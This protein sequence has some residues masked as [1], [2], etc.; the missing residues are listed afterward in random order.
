MKYI[1]VFLSLIILSNC[2]NDFVI[3]DKWKNIPLVYGI[4][5]TSEEFN[6]IRVEKAF[7]DESESAF[8]L[9]QRPDSLY[10]DNIIVKLQNEATNQ[11]INLERINVEDLGIEREAGIFASSPNILYRFKESDFPLNEDQI[12]NLSII[13]GVTEQI[14]TE[15][16]TTIVGQYEI[17]KSA[18]TNPLQFKY[19]SDFTITWRSDE[20]QAVF[21]DVFMKIHYEEQNPDNPSQWV[22]KELLWTLDQNIERSING[23]VFSPR[24][25]FSFNGKKFYEYLAQNI[26][27]SVQTLRAVTGIDII[28]DA[29]GQELLNYIDTGAANTGITSNQIIEPYTNMS[30]GQG[31]FSS[32]SRVEVL[33]Y[34]LNAVTRD[35]LREGIITRHLNFQ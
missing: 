21:Y 15:S 12:V 6:Y 1:L 18:P 13:D 10:Y 27:D 8:T 3:I 17:S 35:S 32:K 30:S 16:T 34:N 4:L 9:A 7:I 23:G 26:D 22:E 28:I 14:L 24:T 19:D 25:T 5:S 29:G 31:I 20:I 2:S 33:D 11:E